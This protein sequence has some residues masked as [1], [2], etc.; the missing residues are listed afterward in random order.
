VEAA[1]IDFSNVRREHVVAAVE[2]IRRDGVPP[3]R[4]AR[5]T[6][7]HVG[8]QSW[9]AKYVL[10]LAWE[11]A[12][13]RA[14][15]PDDYT[16]GLATARVLIGLGFDVDHDDTLLPGEPQAHTTNDGRIA[17]RRAVVASVAMTGTTSKNKAQNKKRIGLLENIVETL[18]DAERPGDTSV[19]VLPG[20]FFRLDSFVGDLAPDERRARLDAADFASACRN[21][22]TA[23]GSI[24]PGAVL[25][26]GVDSV[27][28]HGEWDDQMAVAWGPTGVLGVGRKVFPTKGDEAAGMI[29]NAADFGDAHR[30]V[31]LTRGRRGVLCSCYDGFGVSDPRVRARPIERLRVGGRVLRRGDKGFDVAWESAVSAWTAMTSGLDASLIAI[32]GFGGSGNSS[33]W[34]RHGISTASAALGGGLALAGAHFERLPRSEGVQTLSALRVPASHLGAGH[35]RGAEALPP[36]KSA[37]V[38]EAMVRWFPWE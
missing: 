36:I 8:E 6:T 34:Q 29:I 10:G 11:A 25:V 33:M 30:V 32:H 19:V 2:R 15:D 4:N 38:D 26:V 14:L 17:P 21:A 5:S 22:A 1:V 35:H 37:R 20:G 27:P 12:H 28:G 7:V 31:Q 13:G 23:L 9:P 24:V 3:R 16:G 18:C